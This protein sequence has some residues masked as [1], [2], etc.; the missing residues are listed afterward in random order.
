MNVFLGQLET[1]FSSSTKR[2]VFARQ[3]YATSGYKWIA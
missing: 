1:P 2:N 3:R